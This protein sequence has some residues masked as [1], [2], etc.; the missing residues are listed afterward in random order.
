[1]VTLLRAG[2]FALSVSLHG[3]AFSQAT[4]FPTKAVTIVTPFAAGSG[5]D[6]V[7]RLVSEKL[8]KTWN[9][10]VVVDN[11]PGGGGFIAI[12]AVRRAAA[13]G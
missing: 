4:D 2:A 6:A 9:Q 7:L 5:P 12:E 8:G 1:M 10:R 13:D 11:K 3:L